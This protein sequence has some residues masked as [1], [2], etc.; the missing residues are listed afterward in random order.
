MK[1]VGPLRPGGK[2]GARL[3][4]LAF[5]AR[6]DF[7]TYCAFVAP[8]PLAE[9]Q[10]EFMR[11]VST[12][13][14]E[15]GA[16][17]ILAGPPQWGKTYLATIFALQWIFGRAYMADAR[18]DVRSAIL[19]TY[20][21]AR[22]NQ[23]SLAV[24]QAF[25]D[26]AHRARLVFRDVTLREG[27]AHQWVLN[28][29][30]PNEPTLYATG[31]GGGTGY[32]AQLILLDDY[33]KGLTEAMSEA[34]QRHA[35]EW[36]TGSMQARRQRHTR[37][38]LAA[39]R[40]GSDDLVGR[41]KH[42]PGS[43]WEETAVPAIHTAADGT[44]TSRWPERAP[45][46]F[47]DRQA[48]AVGPLT[49]SAMY[50]C[51]PCPS[52]GLVWDRAWFDQ[53]RYRAGEHPDPAGLEM[54]CAW[55]LAATDYATSDYTGY[56]R[57]GMD[58]AGHIW[59]FNA[60]RERYTPQGFRQAVE[61]GFGGGRSELAV[62]E[63]DNVARWLMRDGFRDLQRPVVG[64]DAIHDKVTRAK[65]VRH[66]AETGRV[67]VPLNAEGEELIRTVV[68]FPSDRYD[69]EHDAFTNLLRRLNAR[70]GMVTDIFYV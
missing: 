29:Q 52:H 28:R 50:L 66:L 7:A 43:R 60:G 22:S 64:I 15:P 36:W 17:V 33:V 69:D 55:D 3:R 51:E 26:P 4:E 9:H 6:H 25:E 18:C 47:L 67:H 27:S 62:L 16:E 8:W 57:G 30:P 42:E 14:A 5:Q 2:Q 61:Y 68:A 23:L 45:L 63:E 41:L 11:P 20:N 21:Q 37:V 10:F 19:A 48:E 31:V 56:C 32:P 39:T 1:S 58:K 53:A 12:V 49:F 24:R 35:W 40:W 65:T 44:R 34:V 13:E 70:A 54:A 46:D 59:I 38:M